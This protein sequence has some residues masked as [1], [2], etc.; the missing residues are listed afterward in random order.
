M[1]DHLHS[2]DTRFAAIQ[3]RRV[4][5]PGKGSP[6]RSGV[7][8]PPVLVLSQDPSFGSVAAGPVMLAVEIARKSQLVMYVT[9]LV[10]LAT[11]GGIDPDNVYLLI[12][13]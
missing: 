5:C 13:Y 7:V 1:I 3:A 6:A 4:V 11:S 10:S 2:W 12:N 9:G 8:T